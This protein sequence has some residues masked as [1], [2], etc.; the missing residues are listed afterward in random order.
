MAS[1]IFY[2]MLNFVRMAIKRGQF[3]GAAG[4]NYHFIAETG[5]LRFDGRETVL[6]P[7]TASLFALLTS[8][9]HRAHSKQ[10]LLDRL[11]PDVCVQDQAVFQCVS[12]I[13]RA[14]GTRACIRTHPRQGYQWA[15]P[16]AAEERRRLPLRSVRIAA[17]I[18]LALVV[19]SDARLV[20]SPT[21][22]SPGP[23]RVAVLPASVMTEL[24]RDAALS[25]GFMEA[26]AKFAGT[27]A[28][29]VISASSVLAEVKDK[30]E[31]SDSAAREILDADLV[32]RTTI[33]RI[34][35]TL[36]MS[37]AI[38]G[39]AGRVEGGY[40]SVSI[41]WLAE[42]VAYEIDEAG[43][44]SLLADGDLAAERLAR[45]QVMANA[46][47][48]L[49]DERPHAAAP[50]FAQAAAD[51]AYLPA[52]YY[53]MTA[54][55]ALGE[56][57]ENRKIGE[58]LRRAKLDG[59][60]LHEA[61]AFL[62]H[63]KSAQLNGDHLSARRHIAAGRSVAKTAKLTSLETSF[64]YMDGV[65]SASVSDYERAAS[66]FERAAKGYQEADCV[67][68]M[69]SAYRHLA[70]AYRHMGAADKAQAAQVKIAALGAIFPELNRP[71]L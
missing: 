26:V 49:F 5:R 27:N 60:K 9:A 19:L 8:E 20:E 41:A 69:L 32:V 28:G 61:R 47:A 59:D 54:R 56:E 23:L 40:E 42:Q 43:R 51:P 50:V 44:Y 58:L 46:R 39:P 52:H 34:G 33:R 30:D 48:K 38:D 10:E 71:A 3:G 37:F 57:V 18:C 15:G 24:P 36:H 29:E 25:L 16:S 2:K 31:I 65:G 6:R 45:H 68:G 21:N 67:I 14:F 11:W 12:E 35:Q 63:A 70:L 64:E 53:S 17:S 7:K 4:L 1:I 62:L 55:I 13:R 22:A 66:S